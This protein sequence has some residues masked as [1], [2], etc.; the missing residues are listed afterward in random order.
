M[1]VETSSQAVGSRNRDLAGKLAVVTGASSGIGRAIAVGLSRLGADLWLVGRNAERLAQTVAESQRFSVKVWSS[2]LDLTTDAGLDVLLQKLQAE[3]G[4]VDILVHSAGIFQ[5]SPMKNARIRDLDLQYAINVR[6]PYLLTQKLMAL[7]IHSQGQ[8]VFINSSA[9]LSTTRAEI[10][11][12]GATKHALKAIAD[13]LRAELNPQGV[14]ILT[15]FLGRTATPMQ[16]AIAHAEGKRYQAHA[17]LQPE[18]VA[19]VVVHALTLP[20]S[21]EVTDISIRPMVKI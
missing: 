15:V 8:V 20:M 16:E 4:R 3:S 11:Q 14:R 19:A 21:A 13:S 18:D 7:L 9:G 10:G 5:Q 17:L 12:Y 1:Q 6:A 2:L